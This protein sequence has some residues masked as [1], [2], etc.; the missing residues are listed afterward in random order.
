MYITQP[1]AYI[2]KDSES[3]V[4]S[5]QGSEVL[6]L[7]ILN[8][9]Q[10]VTMGYIGISPGAMKLCV[11]KGV[12]VSFLSPNGRYISHIN[13]CSRGNVLL[14][15]KQ[16]SLSDDSAFSC[17]ISK[18]F[19]AGKI[20][21]Y[22]QILR[23]FIRDNGSDAEIER[24]CKRLDKH[25]SSV[26]DAEDIS[27]VRGIEGIAANEYFSVFEKL[28]NSPSQ[29]VFKTRSHHPPKDE[30]NALLSYIYSLI[31][32]DV[33]SALETIGLDPYLGYMHTVRP[34]R[35]SLALDMVEE[36][37]AYLGD[38]LAL[39]LIN[40]K[41]LSISDFDKYTDSVMLSEKGRKTVLTQWQERKKDKIT[42]PFLNEKI[43][44]GL[45]PYA[46][47]MLLARYIRGDIDNY[48]VFLIR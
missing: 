27:S 4:V 22:R 38:R 40:R 7:P 44:I 8:I 35:A 28:I 6:R 37:R 2:S 1:D 9:E 41:Q 24:I 48:P 43:S 5:R 13:G 11:D 31:T 19:I 36:F 3:I 20:F 45:L 16:Y 46:Q 25:K 30:V 42:H 47:A 18:L 14:R 17:N 12:S 39:T 32:N 33:I 23:R 21:N 10:I 26:L 15:K 34:G 29:F